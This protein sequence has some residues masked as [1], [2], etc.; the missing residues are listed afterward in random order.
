AALAGI[1]VVVAAQALHFTCRRAAITVRRVAV[2]ATLGAFLR[3]VAAHRIR[4]LDRARFRAAVTAD[5]IAVV[6][7]FAAV[8]HA[9]AARCRRVVMTIRVVPKAAAH[10][11]RSTQP[12]A[13]AHKGRM[14]RTNRD[15][16]KPKK[17]SQ[18]ERF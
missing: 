10:E 3:T 6:A 13:N 12:E 4:R 2:V 9:V 5:L 15:G 8:H 16:F 14:R 1:H 18:A 11:E 17:Y 7:A